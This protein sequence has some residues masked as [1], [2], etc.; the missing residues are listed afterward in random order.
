M[1]RDSRSRG[2]R[3]M[4]AA[5]LVLMV[6]VAALFTGSCS[7]TAERDEGIASS[8]QPRKESVLND[9]TLAAVPAP[10]NLPDPDVPYS[11]LSKSADDADD[12]QT[13]QF[14]LIHEL[15]GYR[16]RSRSQSLPCSTDI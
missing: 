12:P 1:G 4:L 5:V 6:T 8:S 2:G 11:F 13:A 9:G 14:D 7:V 3:R 16:M 10:T 15:R